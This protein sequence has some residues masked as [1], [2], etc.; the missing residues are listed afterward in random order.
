M[1]DLDT[2]L[3][4]ECGEQT[5]VGIKWRQEIVWRSHHYLMIYR[6][7]GVW[8]ESGGRPDLSYANECTV[9]PFTKRGSPEKGQWGEGWEGAE[10]NSSVQD[11]L[12]SSIWRLKGGLFGHL[13]R[14]DPTTIP[15]AEG[16]ILVQVPL[17]EYIKTRENRWD[18]RGKYQMGR[19]PVEP[20]GR[21][22]RF[23]T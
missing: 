11:T 17:T 19:E 3:K 21:M 13:N 7:W 20:W 22:F 5:W 18:H 2:W 6:G 15:Q 14:W 9:L 12:I 16:T 23:K 1:Y 8:K 4:E 10:P